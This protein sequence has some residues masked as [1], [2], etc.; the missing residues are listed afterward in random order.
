L[1]YYGGGFSKRDNREKILGE[2]HGRG[3]EN[4]SNLYWMI[5]VLVGIV[6]Y[7][8]IIFFV[9]FIGFSIITDPHLIYL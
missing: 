3:F 8:Q 9:E 4:M 7:L 5:L 2:N 1:F 6:N